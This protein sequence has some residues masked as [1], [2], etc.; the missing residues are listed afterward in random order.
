MES[1]SDGSEGR[2]EAD[3]SEPNEPKEAFESKKLKWLLLALGPAPCPN[4]WPPPGDTLVT[5]A[6]PAE[7]GATPAWLLP[8]RVAALIGDDD[9]PP[10]EDGGKLALEELFVI[11]APP[12]AAAEPLVGEESGRVGR[13]SVVEAMCACT[14]LAG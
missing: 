6:L 2:A 4:G 12:A 13:E 8:L 14:G 7:G 10:P 5:G 3:S 1:R 11:L 9:A